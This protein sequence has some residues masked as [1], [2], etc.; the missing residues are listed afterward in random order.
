MADN[1]LMTSGYNFEGYS[2][3]DYFGFFSGECALGT[4]FLSSLGAGIADLL[5][6]NS[7]MYSE[8]LKEAKEY[9]I[10]QLVSQAQRVGGNA[11]IGLDVD[12]TTFSADIMGVIA[13]GTAVKITKNSEEDKKTIN[14]KATNS[15]LPFRTTSLIVG[16]SCDEKYFASLDVYHPEDCNV[17]AVLADVEIVTLFDDNYT[18]NDLEFLN[19]EKE[20]MHHLQSSE[21]PL[22]ISSNIFRTIKQVNIIIK[23][24]I[25][26]N[27]VVKLEDKQIDC[28]EDVINEEANGVSLDDILYRIDPLNTAIEISKSIKE[29]N[30]EHNYVLDPTLIEGLEKTAYYERVFGSL[31]SKTNCIKQIR[32]YFEKKAK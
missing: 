20:R 1:I 21:S 29:Y 24:Y 9:A 30:E 32:D 18:I 26:D 31:N 16:K 11:I 4:G 5:G 7:S 6:T 17:S 23:K 8:K 10:N 28:I 2:I 19:F 3:K 15:G 25:E 14:V 22:N 13:S 12:Y 27:N